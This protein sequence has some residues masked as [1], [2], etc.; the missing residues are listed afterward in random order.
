MNAPARLVAFVIGLVVLF[1]TSY[2]VAG[3]VVP[4]R[5]V[6]DWTRSAEQEEHPPTTSDLDAPAT[7][8][9]THEGTH[10]GGGG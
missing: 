3:A 10:E 6:Q 5:V 8:P 7:D 4:E 2:V 1:G 9:D